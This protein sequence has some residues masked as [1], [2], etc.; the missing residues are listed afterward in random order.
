MDRTPLRSD[1]EIA[2]KKNDFERA[3][4]ILLPLAEAE[5]AEA[6]FLLGYLYFTNATISYSESLFWLQKAANQGHAK[7]CYFL[8][9]EIDEL[10]LPSLEERINFLIK[11]ATLGDVSAQRDL[12]CAYATGKIGIDKNEAIGRKWYQKAA[13]QGDPDAQYNLGIMLLRGEGGDK[14][15]DDG[16]KWLKSSAKNEQK[17]NK[18]AAELLYTIYSMGLYGVTVNKTEADKWRKP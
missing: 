4:K 7:A 2:I 9:L 16:I 1:A 13:K 12:G 14:K 3:K 11:S 5:D 17:E 15:I 18:Y 8:S 6:Q 10:E